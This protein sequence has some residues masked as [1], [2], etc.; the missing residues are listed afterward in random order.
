MAGL[1]P[2]NQAILE[3]LALLPGHQSST[4]EM[5]RL[6]RGRQDIRIDVPAFVSAHLRPL[7]DLGLIETT[8]TTGGRGGF[9]TAFKATDLFE[10]RVVQALLARIRRYGFHVSGP[11]L[12]KPLA[13][14]VAEMTDPAGSKDSRGK[15]LELFTLRML[16]FIGLRRIRLR[17][18]P[19]HSEEIDALAEGFAPVHARWQVQCK[20][21]TRLSVEQAAKEVGVAVRQRSTVV[22]LVT[23]G[24]FTDEAIDYIN[25]VVRNSTI[26]IVRI[27]GRDIARLTTDESALWDILAREARRASVLRSGLVDR[28]RPGAPK[29]DE[30]AQMPI[31]AE[32]AGQGEVGPPGADEPGEADQPGAAS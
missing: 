8:K 20:N 1:S 30:A 24:D 16:L 22:L 17:E 31:G 15:A 32:A 13:T 2:E 10:Q 6:L 9:G 14:I 21:T 28:L 4:G 25:D 11:E 23:T 26:T 7:R 12:A 27:N 5:Q 3:Q 29:G 19:T 18:R